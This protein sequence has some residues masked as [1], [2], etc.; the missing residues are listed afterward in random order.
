MISGGIDSTR[1]NMNRKLFVLALLAMLMMITAIP[2][3]GAPIVVDAAGQFHFAND[4]MDKGEYDRA[5]LE[6]ERFIHFFP[7]NRQVPPAQLLIGLCFMKDGRYEKARAVFSEVIKTH[8]DDIFAQKALFLMGE[9]YYRQGISEEAEYYFRRLFR[10][11]PKS[12]LRQAALYRLGWTKMQKSQWKEASRIFG[13]IQDSSPYYQS[14]AGL[15]E[16]SLNGESLPLKSPKLAGTLA[17]VLPG[18]GHAYVGRY[19]DGSVAF[20]VNALFIWA[21]VESFHNDDNVLGGMLCFLELGWYSGN[22]YSAVNVAHK[23]NRKIRR[24]FRSH[25]E[26]RLDLKPLVTP[27]GGAGLTISFRF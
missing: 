24:D 18:L 19:K 25:L 17:A 16:A 9:S 5:I 26:D 20:L 7:E 22:I 6:F 21:A 10:E 1:R 8:H 23:Y 13:D 27:H 12:S 11:F 14:A 3:F 4:L 2:A 15:A